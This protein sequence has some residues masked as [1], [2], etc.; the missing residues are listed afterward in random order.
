MAYLDWTL[1]VAV[2]LAIAA[3]GIRRAR[4][5]KTLHEWYLAGR[6]LP[7]WIVGLSAFA[8]AVD[9]GD[10][11]VVAG[12][13][14]TFGLT[15]LTTWWLG[16]TVGWL[17][18]A[19]F[20]FTP[21]FR[22]GI[23]TNAEWLEYRFGPL[24]S[25]LS[26]FIQ[27]QYRTNVLGNIAWSLYLTLT[28]VGGLSAGPAWTVVILIAALSTVNSARGGLKTVAMT[29]VLQYAAMG[30]ASF[31]LWYVV[32]NSLGG[33]SGLEMRLAEQG[34]SWMLHVGG[35]ER[36]G[37]PVILVVYGWIVALVAYI[38]VNHSQSMR[39]LGARSEWDLKMGALIAGVATVAIMWFNITLG[40]LGR[41]QFP[42]LDVV[43]HVFPL[44]VRDFLAPGLVGLVV[45]GILAA[46][47]STYDSISNALAAL[48][49][50]D[51][52]ARFLR[53]DASDQ[54]Y[55]S[56]SR[57]TVPVVI[58]LGFVYV[59]FLQAGAV[60]FYLS[61]TSVFVLPL[62][63]IYL[64]GALTRVHRSSGVTGLTVGACYGVFA[65]LARTFEWSYPVWLID[66][67]WGYLWNLVLPTSSMLLYSAILDRVRGKVSETD[68]AGLTYWTRHLE[69]SGTS[70]TGQRWDQAP[71]RNW[72]T[73]S[74]LD[75]AGQRKLI[76]PF[77]PPKRGLPWYRNDR[78]L[79]FSFVALMVFLTLFVLW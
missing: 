41:A 74:V 56:V 19:Y 8:T 42:D 68:L 77:V 15:N 33:W 44:L 21:M 61:I 12:G 65:F 23:F 7:W 64:V 45:A 2:N 58:A 14:Y 51:V 46:G 79:A 54:H 1:I 29:N 48:F 25:L 22:S 36:P 20:V 3:Y 18:A 5:T 52:Y 37:V 43:D 13:A 59:P 26:V 55:L 27:I 40:V 57:C 70:R 53:L 30:M 72:L 4:G 11:V 62:A 6:G 73:R 31:L 69:L 49:T 47:M 9:A 60:R 35:Y 28:I 17:L 78:L 39:F 71:Q 16:L 66:L 10:Y 63:A 34:H 75:S 24:T 50:R 32:W 67:W 38:V 76:Y